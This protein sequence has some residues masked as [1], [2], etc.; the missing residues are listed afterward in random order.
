MSSCSCSTSPSAWGTRRCSCGACSWA[1]SWASEPTSCWSR[2]AY[3]RLTDRVP[4]KAIAATPRGGHE[5]C[6]VQAEEQRDGSP[7]AGGAADDGG[8]GRD[9]RQWAA[10]SYAATRP[11]QP[12]CA[13][14]RSGRRSGQT[15]GP[16]CLGGGLRRIWEG[17]DGVP[18]PTV[19]GQG[20]RGGGALRDVPARPP[21]GAVAARGRR[22]VPGLA[23]LDRP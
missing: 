20:R 1:C 13:S 17:S 3:K 21:E 8:A 23:L 18:G 2:P 15:G 10:S 12:G 5:P 7:R 6:P 11:E 9:N 22:L 14:R 19:G 16:P 4:S